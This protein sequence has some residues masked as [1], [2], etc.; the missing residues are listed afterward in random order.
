M[1][2]ER[3]GQIP[4]IRLRVARPAESD[5]LTRLAFRAKENWGY[6]PEDLRAWTDELTISPESI[7]REPTFV[8]ESERRIVAVLQLSTRVSPWEIE[9]LWV[10]PDRMGR[11]FGSRLI[12]HA[13]AYA[14]SQDQSSLAID[15]DPNAE[16][17]YL[18]L[19]ATRVGQEQAPVSGDPARV[20]PQLLLDTGGRRG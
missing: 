5:E 20:R 7:S 4:R 11:G 13:I 2:A 10:H 14:A 9:G 19:G 1:T 12:R 6:S 17:F 3:S 16:A 18:A 15:A 8:I